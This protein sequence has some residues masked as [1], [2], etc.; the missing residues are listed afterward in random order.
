MLVKVEQHHIDNGEQC[1]MES[2]A[3]ALAVKDATGAEFVVADDYGIEWGNRVDGI[4]R[5]SGMTT[6][7]NI[8]IFMD[9]YDFGNKVEPFE[10]FLVEE[11]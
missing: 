4:L 10:F 11:Y 3:I 7:M 1:N 2:C 9:N 6:S 8:Q 5:M